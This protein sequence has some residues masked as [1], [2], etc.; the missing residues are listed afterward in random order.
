[1]CRGAPLTS[2][3]TRKVI[4]LDFSP[5]MAIIFAN[6]VAMVIVEYVNAF[7]GLWQFGNWPFD[8]IRLINIPVVALLA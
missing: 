2:P 7:L 3:A 6:L 4:N 8:N 5:V 1:M